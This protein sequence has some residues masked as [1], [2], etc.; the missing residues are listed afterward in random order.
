[1]L[2]AYA[3]VCQT[4]S[5]LMGAR[6]MSMGYASACL[7]D[8]WSILNNPAGLSE[9]KNVT[10]AF[11]YNAYPTFKSFNR[12]AATFSVPSKFGVTG[13]SVFK[14]GDDLYNE[15][16]LSMA[17]ANRFGLAS[18][19]LQINYLQYQAQSFGTTG[20]FTLSMG[21]IATL[22]PQLMI[23]AYVRNINQPKIATGDEDE[24][25]PTLLSAGLAFKPSDKVLLC[26][27]IEKDLRRQTKFKTGVEYIIHK[28]FTIRTGVNLNPNAGFIGFG[29]NTKKIKLDYGLEYSYNIG[30]NHQA[31]VCYKFSKK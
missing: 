4:S 24:Y 6:A 14:F 12:M 7:Q 16:L 10:S 22:T 5:T 2:S 17:F 8:E 23:G 19:G 1:M 28:K 11:S 18:L 30:I 20:V 15:Q 27:E 29:F 26:T 3:A 25:V 21:G 31:T 9:V 13:I